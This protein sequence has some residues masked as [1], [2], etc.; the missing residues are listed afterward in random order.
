MQWISAPLIVRF[1]LLPDSL[2]TAGWGGWQINAIGAV[3]SG[4]PFNVTYRDAGADRDVG[5]NRPD[6]VGDAR[7]GSGDGIN[8]PDFIA[9]A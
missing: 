9:T 1:T 5:P 6:L 3:R 2:A 7:V 8:E 4:L